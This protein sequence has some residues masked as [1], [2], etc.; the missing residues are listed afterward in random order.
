MFSFLQSLAF[1]RFCSISSPDVREITSIDT[2]PGPADSAVVVVARVGG[3]VQV[4][5]LSYTPQ[6]HC[7]A[8]AT[9]NTSSGLVCVDFTTNPKFARGRSYPHGDL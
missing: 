9:L 6:I 4:F 7:T 1:D 3:C 2:A 8:S 5:T